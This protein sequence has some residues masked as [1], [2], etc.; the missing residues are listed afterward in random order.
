MK[1]SQEIYKE[2]ASSLVE[3]AEIVL[4]GLLLLASLSFLL[5]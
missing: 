1:T 3:L 5:N 4:P 2:V